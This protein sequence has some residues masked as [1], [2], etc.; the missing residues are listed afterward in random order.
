MTIES[1]ESRSR[2]GRG[3]LVFN[4]VPAD[5]FSIYC[6]EPSV[7]AGN[8]LVLNQSVVERKALFV[9]AHRLPATDAGW[10]RAIRLSPAVTLYN[11]AEHSGVGFAGEKLSGIRKI[12]K[13]SADRRNSKRVAMSSGPREQSASTMWCNIGRYRIEVRKNEAKFFLDSI[14][15]G[16]YHDRKFR[17]DFPERAKFCLRPSGGLLNWWSN[18]LG[19]ADKP[20][21]VLG[22]KLL[23]K[24]ETDRQYLSKIA[25]HQPTASGKRIAIGSNQFPAGMEASRL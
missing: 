1:G 14:A 21:R 16:T 5:E 23:R 24:A 18:F 11:R 13:L 6:I 25:H 3:A 22:S 7:S 4:R 17:S 12:L 2:L 10:H 9:P 19:R 20:S 8:C 15:T